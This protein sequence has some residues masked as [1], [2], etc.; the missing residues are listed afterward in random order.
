MRSDTQ[1]ITIN[2]SKEKLFGFLS[3]PLNLPKWAVGLCKS[4]HEDADGWI[5]ETKLGEVGLNVV[6]NSDLGIIDY[7]LS[8]ALPIKIFVYSRVFPNGE[9][10]EYIFTQFQFPLVTDGI[11]EEQKELLT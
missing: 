4:V 11:F 3:D 2:V 7:H 8:P 1:T 5:V 10:S 6:A 9:W